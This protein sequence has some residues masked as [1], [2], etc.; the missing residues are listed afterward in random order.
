MRCSGSIGKYHWY[1]RQCVVVLAALLVSAHVNAQSTASGSA[2]PYPTKPVRLVLG[3][4]PG[5][6]FDITARIISTP[7]AE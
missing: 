4:A 2:Q 6:G 5:G 3:T 1:I 7:L